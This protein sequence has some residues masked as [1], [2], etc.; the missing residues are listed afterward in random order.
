MRIPSIPG[1]DP[2]AFQKYFKNTGWLM[3]GKVLSLIVGIFIAKFLGPHDFGDL[4]VATA[5]AA[6]IAAVGTLGLDS[7]VIREVLDHPGKRDEI[8]GTAFWMRLAVSVV[9]V[10]AS[11][12]IY[13]FS[14]SIDEQQGT[15]LTLVITF[16]AS[17]L[18][19]K[20]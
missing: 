5:F 8:L 1:F 18:L 10:P 20:S 2:E 13:I 9:L 19:F 3:F 4:S 6:I 17:A 11:V 16:C 15:D 14:R 7:F 12:L